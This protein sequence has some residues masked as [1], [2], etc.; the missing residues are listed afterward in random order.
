MISN[1]CDQIA[2]SAWFRY[3]ILG[4]I[5]LGGILV[6]L[7]TSKQIMAQYGVVIYAL[8]SMVLAIFV[9]EMIIRIAA[10]GKR[11]DRF[12][13]DPWNLFDFIIVA[14]CLLPASTEYLA[15]VRLARILRV[16]RLISILPRLQFLVGALLKSVPSIGYITVL[17]GLFFYIY[18]CVGVFL[19]RYN[20]PV[21]FGTLGS[22]LLTLF[23]VVTLEGWNNIFH[24]QLYGSDVFGYEG[25]EIAAPN[26]TAF[27]IIAPLYFISFILICTMIILNLFIG[28]IMKG[29][30]EMQN[31]NMARDMKEL[32]ER[33]GSST[34][35]EI[36]LIVNSLHELED[37]LKGVQVRLE[38]SDM[39]AEKIS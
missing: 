29:M 33:G 25:L 16:L 37:R 28:V 6:G 22:S 7:E 36:S 24:L 31:E 11:P 23:E 2:Q 21:H 13:T 19:F 17:L 15:V 34:S 3:S 26:P 20:D 5:I 32:E 8:D 38:Q 14:A 18:A 10:Y 9:V 35:E 12:F 27:P 4:V 30:E 1:T 39:Q